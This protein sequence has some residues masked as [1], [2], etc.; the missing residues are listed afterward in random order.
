MVSLVLRF[1]G[2]EENTDQE[3]YLKIEKSAM[4][5][6]NLFK[7]FETYKKIINDDEQEGGRNTH[8]FVNVS[9]RC[10]VSSIA[11]SMACMIWKGTTYYAHIEYTDKTDP[12]DGL[13]DEDVNAIT[14]AIYSLA[15]MAESM[16]PKISTKD[17]IK[18]ALNINQ[19]AVKESLRSIGI[20]VG[21]AFSGILVSA[22]LLVNGIIALVG[23][24][25]IP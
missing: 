11:G 19:T 22:I 20:T 3:K 21:L 1:Y 16:S 15:S 12:E 13:P 10:K 23:G 14:S 8:V 9:T 17:I 25:V 7:Y 4:N 5:I 18:S 6:W 2:Q 24:T